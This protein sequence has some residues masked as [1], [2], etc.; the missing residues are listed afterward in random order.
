VAT[1]IFPI[2]AHSR[3]YVQTLPS[4][5]NKAVLGR[6]ICIIPFYIQGSYKM[7][8]TIRTKED[9]CDLDKT[10]SLYSHIIPWVHEWILYYEIYL[11]T[12]I[13]EHPE[14]K[15]GPIKDINQKQ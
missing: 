8:T 1:D 2:H 13:W 3:P 4:Y 15:H 11:I 14:V 6:I 12:G 5:W 9:E 10:C 7:G